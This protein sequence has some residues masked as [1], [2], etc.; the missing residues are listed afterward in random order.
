MGAP[1]GLQV[2]LILS[3]LLVRTGGL[4]GRPQAIGGK[5]PLQQG[6]KR[7]QQRSSASLTKTRPL[8]EPLDGKKFHANAAATPSRGEDPRPGCR[9]SSKQLPADMCFL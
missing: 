7:T 1:L 5:R 6:R 2:P 8:T 4:V 3:N 9:A